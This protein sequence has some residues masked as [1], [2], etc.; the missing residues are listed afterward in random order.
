MK[1]ATHSRHTPEVTII[2]LSPDHPF[3]EYQHS[4]HNR[5]ACRAYEIFEAE[6]RVHGHDVEQWLRAEA[7]L[8]IPLPTKIQEVDDW[9]FVGAHVPDLSTSELRIYAEPFRIFIAAE[10]KGAGKDQPKRSTAKEILTCVE[11]PEPISPGGSFAELRN[12]RLAMGFAKAARP[13]DKLNSD[14]GEVLAWAHKHH[15]R[16]DRMKTMSH[17]AKD[18][19]KAAR[20]HLGRASKKQEKARKFL[21][22][23]TAGASKPVR[24]V[25]EVPEWTEEAPHSPLD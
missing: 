20:H 3:Y 19:A 24:T 22:E 25:S 11:L 21:T 16:A 18:Y 4:L 7:E 10:G 6:G 12:G 14:R 17:A 23:H 15:L 2:S 5:I 9:I 8:L 13:V 1:A